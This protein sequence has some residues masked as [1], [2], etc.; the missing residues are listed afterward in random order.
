MRTR[1]AALATDR[2]YVKEIL[3]AGTAKAD[4]ITRSVL[5]T[6]RQAFSLEG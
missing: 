4:A 2:T 1:R 5:R 6:I 3:D